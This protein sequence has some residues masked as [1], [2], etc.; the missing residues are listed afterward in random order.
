MNYFLVAGMRRSGSTMQYH[1]ARLL[2]EQSGG[3]GVWYIEPGDFV[4]RRPVWNQMPGIKVIKV[5]HPDPVLGDLVTTGEARAIYSWRDP[6]DVVVSI[7]LRARYQD[8]TSLD[9]PVWVNQTFRSLARDHAFWTSIPC[10]PV[11]RYQDVIGDAPGTVQQ[12]ARL[13]SQAIT[14]TQARL[15]AAQVTPDQLMKHKAIPADHVNDGRAGM[16]QDRTTDT[17]RAIVQA[18]Y[19]AVAHIFEDDHA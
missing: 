4:A 5:H 17:Q 16:W 12:I 18:G 15:I 11:V 9:N 6:R 8:T 1:I 10:V 2:A 14:D 13:M 19:Q 7:S 3:R